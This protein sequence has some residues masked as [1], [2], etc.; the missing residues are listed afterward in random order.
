MMSSA[1]CFSSSAMIAGTSVLWPAA[2]VL[3]PTACTSFSI[4]WRA[5]SS[6][7]WNSGPMSTSKPR[8]AKAVA[9]TLSPRSWPSWPSL[10][11]IADLAHRGAQAHGLDAE[12]QQV[13]VVV[14]GGGR[15]GVQ[16]GLHRRAV[17]LGL[18]G[19]EPGDLALA[20]GHVVDVA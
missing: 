2:S 3:T 10:E 12:V 16:R 1:P 11:I 14:F 17:A 20:H 4:A 18:D 19:L 6:G 13:A 9:T 7:V 15:Q 8:S 5:H